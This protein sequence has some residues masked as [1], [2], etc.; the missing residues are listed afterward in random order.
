MRG[1]RQK[2]HP[3]KTLALTSGYRF[4]VLVAF[5]FFFL[6]FSFRV[7]HSV[8]IPALKKYQIY[9]SMVDRGSGQYT[10]KKQSWQRQVP[11]FIGVLVN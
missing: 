11:K 7:N 10:T 8:Q 9:R 5:F 4:W 2:L 1:P 6:F 3:E